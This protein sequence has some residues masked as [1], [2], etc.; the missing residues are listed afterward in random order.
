VDEQGLIAGF[1][2][3]GWD[4]P[5][6]LEPKDY[7][8]IYSQSEYNNFLNLREFVFMENTFVS[9]R[10]LSFAHEAIHNRPVQFHRLHATGDNRLDDD[11]LRPEQPETEIQNHDYDGQ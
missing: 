7:V 11:I 3:S 10:A 2:Q 1:N 9:Q 8:F 5:D 6:V 4:I